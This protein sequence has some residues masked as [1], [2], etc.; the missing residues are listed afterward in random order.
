MKRTIFKPILAGIALGALF[1]FAG[2]LILVVLLLKFIFTPFGMGRRGYGWRGGPFFGGHEMQWAF[3]EKLRSM[4][5]EEY[6]RYKSEMQERYQLRGHYP[7][8]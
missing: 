4:N 2:P 6:N 1:F 8:C 5:D 7:Y 3:A